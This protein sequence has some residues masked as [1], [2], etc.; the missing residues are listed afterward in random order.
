LCRQN[1]VTF[2]KYARQIK[3]YGPLWI[4]ALCIN[5]AD[6]VERNSQVQMMGEIYSWAKEVI[7]CLGDCEK[8][9]AYFAGLRQESSGNSEDVLSETEE[10]RL[11]ACFRCEYW[12]RAWITQELVLAYKPTFMAGP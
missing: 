8:I 1:L 12:E 9:T 7:S 10:E 4:D 5:Q 2:L 11:Q 3:I 6:I